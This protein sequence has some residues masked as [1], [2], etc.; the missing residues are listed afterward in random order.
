M[1][2]PAPALLRLAA[3][4]FIDQEPREGREQEG[5]ELALCRIRRLDRILFQ[6]PREKL[7][8]QI[9]IVSG[10]SPAA[11][12]SRRRSSASKSSSERWTH[13]PPRF[14]AWPRSRSLI[15]N[16]VRAVSK[17]VRNLPFAASAAWIEFFSNNR[18]KNS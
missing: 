16:R 3:F 2:A 14:C 4:P 9:Q 8:S 15:R 12:S 1:D 6:Q 18:A 7:L 13:P 10:V 17:K 11:G 5:A